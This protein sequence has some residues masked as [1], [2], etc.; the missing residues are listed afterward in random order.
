MSKRLKKPSTGAVKAAI[1][2]PFDARIL[3]QAREIV[4]RY[5]VIIQ[6]DPE[7]GYL[8]RGLE[9]PFAMDDGR[10]PDECVTNTR[11]AMVAAVATMLEKGETP[12]SPS[13]ERMRTEQINIRVTPEEKLLLEESARSKGFRGIS[14]FVRSTSLS[15]VR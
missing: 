15:S 12:P 3:K 5:S 1:D 8:G 13:S 2:R 4:A 7:L 14:D 6:P 10:T 11:K 9:F